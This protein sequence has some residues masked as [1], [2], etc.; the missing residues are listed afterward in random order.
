MSGIIC[1]D[2]TNEGKQ[3][4]MLN[5][6]N[7]EDVTFIRISASGS[8]IIRKF[9]K[10]IWS[11]FTLAL[12]NI[13]NN[14]VNS[15]INIFGLAVGFSV[16]ILIMLYVHH[17]LSFDKF[18]VHA[19]R[20]YR[21]TINASLADGK[22]IKA[23]IT[24]GDIAPLLA[25]NV[26]DV[27]LV[28]RFY[29]WS[30]REIMV[31]DQRFTKCKLLYTDSTFFQIFS[32]NLIQGNPQTALV[33]PNSVVLTSSTAKKFFGD[34]D[35]MDKTIKIAGYEQRITGI[36]ED[37]PA[38]SHLNCELIASFTSLLRPDWNIVE[39]NGISFPTYILVHEEIEFEDFAQKTILIADAK[40]EERFGPHGIKIKHGLQ[41]L[42]EAYL[43]S[44]LDYNDN[45][46][47]DIR[48]VYIFSFLALIIILIA[49]FN[50][51]NLFTAQSERRTREIGLR[52]V[53]GATKGDLVKQFIGESVIVSL[54]ALL[55]AFVF[56]E[57]LISGFAGL[58]D[59]PVKIIYWQD[60]LMLAAIIL[61]ALLTGILAGM[62]PALYLSGL[63]PLKVLKGGAHGSGKPYPIRKLLV[64]GQFAITIFLIISVILLQYQ[65]RLMKN[66]DLGFDRENVVTIESLTNKVYTSYT[67]LKADLLANP[68]ILSVTA[69]QSAP[70]LDRSLQNC[71][72][73]GND[74]QTAILIFENRI[75]H[76]YI[77]TFGINL[78]EGRDFDPLMKTDSAAV[79][80]NQQAVEKLGL[81]SPIGEKVYVWS[82]LSTVIGVMADYNYQSLHQQIDPLALTMYE[83]WFSRISIRIAPGKTKE[84]ME[85]IEKA[86]NEVDPNYTMEY[87][88]V[89][90]T[91]DKMYRKEDRMNSM[92][93]SAAVLAI[94]I[95]ILGLYALTS[96]T[97]ARKV[98]EIGIR[99]ALGAS[100]INVL[101][102]LYSDLSR[103]IIAG[104]LIAWPLS[105]WAITK[106]MEN[107][108]YRI[109]LLD[110]WWVFAAGG[111]LAM[112]IGGLT[113]ILKAIN[114]ARANPVDSLRYE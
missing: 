78:V 36:M 33:E 79:I 19:D 23:A 103:W 89:D 67:S 37:F 35:P 30:G 61:F 90:E 110:Y 46:S 85:F 94:V 10:M 14:K 29:H 88:F 8:L 16:S 98:K 84:T 114:A 93:A 7:P 109:N 73:Q 70:G 49:V 13:T 12:R 101:T 62:Y 64:A 76:D 108:A 99:K 18:H 113:I 11:Y 100:E 47:G 75:Q 92:I 66:K 51:M 74:P 96:F 112:M 39:N 63:M 32:F 55:M 102:L 25:D 26:A 95:S 9:G 107:F 45:Q 53:L 24:S 42:K 17:Q 82:N 21:L 15:G 34:E 2:I 87:I 1:F 57:I 83:K 48:N 81:T 77:K 80:L 4:G 91:F 106:W 60:P 31:D 56:N 52:K 65:I 69:S 5:I 27:E 58:L 97:I 72:I 86:L 41:P 59:E 28:T 22:E 44:N 6:V 43:H 104:N 68:D 50:F 38:N 20:I 71:Y 3:V 105:F 54:L 40:T 111:L